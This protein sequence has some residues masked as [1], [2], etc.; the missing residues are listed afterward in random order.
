MTLPTGAI[1]LNDVATELAIS[2]S[3]LSLNDS[4]VRG[5]AGIP[6]GAIS[7][8]DLKGKVY[9]APYT[10]V[11]ASVGYSYTYTSSGYGSVTPNNLFKGKLFNS[12]TSD[13]SQG[14]PLIFNYEVGFNFSA[15]TIAGNTFYRSLSDY[16]SDNQTYW[17]YKNSSTPYINVAGTP[18][19]MSITGA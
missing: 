9:T 3:G 2:S 7:L 8:N 19:S 1:S 17:L 6:S 16:T 14:Y 18:I 10:L 11:L 13:S 12:I 15:I 4:R 5:L